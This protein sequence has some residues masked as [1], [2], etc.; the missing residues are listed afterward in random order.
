MTQKEA[1]E[2]VLS[3]IKHIKT[4]MPNGELKQMQKDMG[5]MKEDISDLKYT[6]LNP[7]NGVI[8]STNKNT[9]YRIELQANEKDFRFQ[10]LELKELKRWKDGVT[11]ALW[12]IFGTI[13]AIIF[14][15]LSH[16]GQ[17]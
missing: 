17:L 7:D 11:K 12:I 4:H 15:I 16:N 5:D 10:M 14:Q 2:L 3:E 8:V 13:V 9:E 6:L 1:L